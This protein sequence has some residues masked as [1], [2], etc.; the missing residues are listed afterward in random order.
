MHFSMGSHHATVDEIRWRS[1]PHRPL[2]DVE[3]TATPASGQQPPRSP[4]KGTPMQ[5]WRAKH[6]RRAAAVARAALKGCVATCLGLEGGWPRAS[7]R[8]GIMSIV[9]LRN[10]AM[11]CDVQLAAHPSSGKGAMQGVCAIGDT[12]SLG[13]YHR[14]EKPVLEAVVR[15]SVPADDRRHSDSSDIVVVLDDSGNDMDEGGVDPEPASGRRGRHI[16]PMATRMRLRGA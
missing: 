4:T 9:P 3:N 15:G 5:A 1:V 13:W 8:T 10:S 6:P 14:R 16:L 2:A 11:L 12:L 7:R